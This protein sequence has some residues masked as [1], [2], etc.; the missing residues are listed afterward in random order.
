VKPAIV[1]IA[2][3]KKEKGQIQQV[4]TATAHR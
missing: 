2:E 3:P 4:R 1:R